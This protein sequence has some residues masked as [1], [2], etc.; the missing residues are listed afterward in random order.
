MAKAKLLLVFH[1]HQPTGNIE[2][3][4]KSATEDCYRPLAEMLYEF[5]E[6]KFSLHTTGPLWNWLE[7]NVPVVFEKMAEMVKRGQLEI[8]GGGFYE[9]MLAVLPE[10]DAIG[11]LTLMR[12]RIRERFGYEARGLWTAERV[13]EPDLARVMA[14]GG[15]S[16]TLLDDRHFHSAGLSGELDGYY[17]TE[18]AGNPLAV[19]PISQSL[20]YAIPFQS[21]SDAVK[22]ILRL[23][24]E[25]GGDNVVLTYGDDGEKF[26]VWPGTKSLVWERGWLRDFLNQ[27]RDMRDVIETSTPSEILDNVAPKGRIYLPTASYAEMGEW[28]LTPTAQHQFKELHNLIDTADKALSLYRRKQYI[29]D[30]MIPLLELMDKIPMKWF[31]TYIKFMD[32]G[33]MHLLKGSR[34]L[35]SRF[36][37]SS[38]LVSKLSSLLHAVEE[39]SPALEGSNVLLHIGNEMSEVL[40]SLDE[41]SKNVSSASTLKSFVQGGIWQGFLGKYHEANLVHKRMVSVS[42]RLAQLEVTKPGIDNGLLDKARDHLYQA[43]CNCAYWHGIFGGLYMVHLR[44]A[45]YHHLL[46]A[47]H[48]MDRYD[49]VTE[50]SV[51]LVDFDADFAKE[52]V[53]SGPNLFAL[54]KPNLGAGLLELDLKDRYFN[55]TNVMTRVEEGY[56]KGFVVKTDDNSHDDG[57]VTIHHHVDYVDES[58]MDKRIYDFGPRFAFQDQFLSADMDNDDL[59]A[60]YITRKYTDIGDFAFGEWS[61]IDTDVKGASATFERTGKV[62]QTSVRIQKKYTLSGSNL[63]VD[64][65]FELPEG[66]D[67]NCLFVPESS[68]TL[69]GHSIDNRKLLINGESHAGALGYSSAE[70]T[71]TKVHSMGM[72]S[73]YDGFSWNISWDGDVKVLSFPFHSLSKSETGVEMNYQGTS[74]SPVF[75]LDFTGETVVTLSFLVETSIFAPER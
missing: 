53:F 17:V 39:L 12:D 73:L 24:E 72:K 2:E 68:F 70:H 75:P 9:P 61:V 7:A 49:D 11:Q 35:L 71:F 30:Y 51:K 65:R 18:K 60:K 8:L 34:F 37:K 59:L 66:G 50:D 38:D 20:R 42:D 74:L 69:L 40:N 22:T 62:G 13:W 21:P 58:F 48:L 44:H 14:A 57:T 33:G 5:P 23:A 32:K 6:L 41:I 46:I 36:E 1:N 3:V 31:E 52:A 63:L 45:L 55:L 19:F 15:Y 27:L 47:E 4:F 67:L 43:Q 10:R 54:V 56:H 28:V 29:R 25:K 26:G 64:Y 16:Y